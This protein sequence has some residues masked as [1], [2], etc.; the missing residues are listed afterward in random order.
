MKR[1]AIKRKTPM[2]HGTATLERT[3][4]KKKARKHRPEYHDKR[5]LNMCRGQA[6]YLCMPGIACS[7]LDS[8]VPA[9]SNEAALGKGAGLKAP[10][11]YTVPACHSHHSEL[12]QGN[13]FTKDEKKR[14]WRAAYAAWGPIREKLFGVPY[15]PLPDNL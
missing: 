6:C 9:H 14:M 5:M 15:Q 13:K 8:V 12:D 1:T 3:P 11:L 7:E 2:S 10:D 4:M